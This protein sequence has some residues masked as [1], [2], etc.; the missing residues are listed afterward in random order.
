M[1]KF[2]DKSK[3]SLLKNED[4]KKGTTEYGDVSSTKDGTSSQ[5]KVDVSKLSLDEYLSKYTSEDNQSF[6]VLHDK[7]REEFLKRISWMFND[8]EKHARLNQLAL[9]HG[10][11]ERITG[12]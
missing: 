8:N 1:E 12:E 5:K 7:E 3:E 11:K 6:Q 9:E 10:A 2:L 4:G